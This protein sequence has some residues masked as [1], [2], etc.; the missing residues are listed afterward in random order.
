MELK[1]NALLDK[2]IKNI[3]RTDKLDDI[4]RGQEAANDIL[5]VQI[6]KS[7]PKK[8]SKWRRVWKKEVAKEKIGE[9]ESLEGKFAEKQYDIFTLFDLLKFTKTEEEEEMPKDNKI[10]TNILSEEQI[11][12]ELLILLQGGNGDFIHFVDDK[13]AIEGIVQHHHKSF[14][15][16]MLSIVQ[17]VQLVM[18]VGNKLVGIVGQAISLHFSNELQQFIK[19]ILNYNSKN[20]SLLSLHSYL[21]SNECEKMRAY[22]IIGHMLIQGGTNYLN[23]L[24]FTQSHGSQTIR[25]VGAAMIESGN[26]VILEFVRDWVLYGSIN[27]P[28]NEFFI[29]GRDEKPD[30]ATWWRERYILIKERIPVSFGDASM[31]NKELISMI[32]SCGRAINY[33]ERFKTADFSAEKHIYTSK[34]FDLSMV[35]S[36]LDSAMSTVMDLVMNQNWLIGHLNMIHDFM[37]FCRGDFAVSLYNS[38]IVRDKSES[39]NILSHA[40]NCIQVGNIYVNPKT[41][42]NLMNYLDLKIVNGKDSTVDI[43][44][45]NISI[46]Y[47]L[48]EPIST[49][50]SRSDMYDYTKISKLLWHMKQI[51]MELSIPWKLFKP[52]RVLKELSIDESAIRKYNAL[53]ATLLYVS[54]SLN[55]WIWTDVILTSRKVMEEKMKKAT[56]FDEVQKIHR[57]HIQ[58]LQRGMLLADQFS[59]ECTA[60]TN[61]I[62]V[63]DA[64]IFKM[65]ELFVYLTD[66]DNEYNHGVENDD[67]DE[68]FI[69][70]AETELKEFS[71]TFD[72]ISASYRAKLRA[73]YILTSNNLEIPELSH[74]ELR[75]K[76]CRTYRS[77]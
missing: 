60:L 20:A 8:Y 64:F 4:K 12:S 70:G 1:K 38:A 32:L 51:Q 11:V 43:D 47:F 23:T 57:R 45:K 75:L 34:C 44:P 33:I 49:V 35:P 53:R 55:E 17:C 52:P 46:T 59:T 14:L 26:T 42:E 74:L 40:K 19:Y 76:S 48:H 61:L 21:H 18:D 65:N 72:N 3:L 13:F 77:Y 39:I 5:S 73:L 24:S 62:D 29:T 36:F 67:I 6:F 25:E 2:L 37:L 66:L 71:E 54:I 58:T 28:Y 7:A 68:Y 16:D 31:T 22:A 27:D 63:L 9:L 30:P 56:R 69:S 50:I 15:R 10:F 41:K